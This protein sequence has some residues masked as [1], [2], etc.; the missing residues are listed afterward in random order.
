MVQGAGPYTGS[1]RQLEAD[2]VAGTKKVNEL[3]GACGSGVVRAGG[4]ALVRRGNVCGGAALGM[5]RVELYAVDK[6]E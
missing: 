6:R 5:V 3:I 1:I 4:R 2:I